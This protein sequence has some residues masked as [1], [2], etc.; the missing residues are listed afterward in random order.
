VDEYEKTIP[1]KSISQVISLKGEPTGYM[2]PSGYVLLSG[3]TVVED[4]RE[5]RAVAE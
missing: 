3:G 4:L 5:Q 2:M 1:I